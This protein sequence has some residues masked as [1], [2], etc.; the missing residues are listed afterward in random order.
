MFR[1]LALLSLFGYAASTAASLTVYGADYFTLRWVFLA[2][3]AISGG[4]A[5]SSEGQY[6]PYNQSITA[7]V[8]G[9]LVLTGISVI[10]SI[11]VDY[12]ILRWGSHA[13]MILALVVF[14]RA[15]MIAN[16]VD[17]LIFF[18]KVVLGI[19]VVASYLWPAPPTV[20][21]MASINRGI[22]GNANSFGQLCAVSALLFGHGYLTHPHLWR[23]RLEGA[24]GIFS[25]VLMWS[26]GSRSALVLLI[27]GAIVIIIVYKKYIHRAVILAVISAA[28]LML[29][30]PQIGEDIH[31]FVAKWSTNPQFAGTDV[32][33]GRTDIWTQSWDGFQA[34][35]LMGWGFGADANFNL[36]AWTN[37]WSAIAAKG[38]DGV[39]DLLFIME[40]TGLYGLFGYLLLLVV[41]LH[42]RSSRFLSFY[43]GR[44]DLS[45]LDI[46]RH[47]ALITNYNNHS[48]CFAISLA[49]LVCF[50]L[51]NTA[52]SAG[53][54]M[55][56][57]FWV[58][59]AGNLVSWNAVR[60]ALLQTQ[61]EAG[62]I[63]PASLTPVG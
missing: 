55:S 52:L 20:Y 36:S 17:R 14:L 30:F 11:S 21:D 40:G 60:C 34:R 50:Q 5:W 31:N 38:R 12:S 51:D 26:S 41:V 16:D 3:V 43:M 27:I 61:V 63:M 37:Q 54:F 48:I 4:L 10:Q 29:V 7:L 33:T 23:A 57:A 35:L 28:F 22:M 56:V 9:Y 42:A 25:A 19:T 46:E 47:R 1:N 24:L 49:M 39:N 32:L 45:A 15:S 6:Q 53:N 59:V 62:S 8:V 2:A 13:L 58:L 44:L 18:L